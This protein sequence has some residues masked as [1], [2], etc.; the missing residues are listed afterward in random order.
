MRWSQAF[1]SRVIAFGII[2]FV[3]TGLP[4][5]AQV[6]SDSV[7]YSFCD[8]SPTCSD[9]AFPYSGLTI[10]AVGNLYGTTYAGGGEGC[11]SIGCGSVF[12]LTPDG[13]SST[14]FTEKVLHG[15]LSFAVDGALPEAAVTLDHAGNVYG[16]TWGGGNASSDCGVYGCGAVF[17]LTPNAKDEWTETILYNFC[18]T[19]NCKDG[20]GPAANLVFD[21][22]GNLYGTTATGGISGGKCPYGCGTVFELS[23]G[24]NGSWLENVLFRFSYDQGANPLAGLTFDSAGNLYGTTAQGGNYG[25]GT[26]FELTL[27][28][29]GKWTET[30]LH[31]FNT[32]DGRVPQ[33]GVIFDASGNL[34]GTTFLGGTGPACL[35]TYGCGTVY[36]LSPGSNGDWN[37]QVLYSFCAKANCVDGSNPWGG[38]VSNANGIMYGTTYQGGEYNAGILFKLTFDQTWTEN[39]LYTFGT[40]NYDALNPEAGSLIFDAKGNLYGTAEYGGRS[41]SCQNLSSCGSVFV[42]NTRDEAR[43]LPDSP[44]R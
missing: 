38:L 6:S 24:A 28:S 8:Y 36:E 43:R 13:L 14:G 15:F 9:G 2:C 32:T 33:S 44:E 22:A 40:S 4:A 30:V 27:G 31:S 25:I 21:T 12:R 17:E 20:S 42:W 23:P 19:L 35:Y 1:T 5:H 37:E 41:S 7:V 10:D 39:L 18:S 34:Y 26:V 16:T 3:L 29:N 11:G